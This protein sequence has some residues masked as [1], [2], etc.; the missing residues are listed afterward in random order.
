MGSGLR[1]TLSDAR[2]AACGLLTKP[3]GRPVECRLPQKQR[4]LTR[5][6]SLDQ[7]SRHGGRMPGDRQLRNAGGRHAQTIAMPPLTCRVSPV[8]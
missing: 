3:L 2:G 1:A 7:P 5:F 6:Q 8:T 4:L